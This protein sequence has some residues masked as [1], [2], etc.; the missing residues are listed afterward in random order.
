MLIDL[1]N[2]KTTTMIDIPDFDGVGVVQVEVR[3]PRLTDMLMND[4]IPNPLRSTALM[5]VQGYQNTGKEENREDEVKRT[6]EV[7]ELYCKMCLVNPSYA[8]FKDVITDEQ[9]NAIAVWAHASV[10]V[11]RSF[12]EQQENRSDHTDGTEVQ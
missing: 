2:A 7:M 3:R 5:V 4:K 1:K 12:R 6:I 9:K 10:S 11:L 8:E